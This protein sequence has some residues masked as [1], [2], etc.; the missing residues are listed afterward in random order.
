MRNIADGMRN[1]ADRMRNIADGMRNIADGNCTENK[2]I[3]FC[4]QK[5]FFFENRAVYE[6]SWKNTVQLERPK[7]TV[8]RM[9]IAS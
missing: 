5:L 3:T 6:I 7:M 8:W 2:N 1:I 9:R 4:V